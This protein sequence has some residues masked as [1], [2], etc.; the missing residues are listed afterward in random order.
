MIDAVFLPHEADLIKSIPLSI[1]LLKDKLVWAANS[2]DLF[3][4]YSAYK[5]AMDLSRLVNYGTRDRK[6]VV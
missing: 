3:S 5:L 1:Q 6:S 2:N 4:V